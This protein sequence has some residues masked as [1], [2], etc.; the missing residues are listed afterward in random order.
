[1]SSGKT[2]LGRNGVPF[3][4]IFVV[5]SHAMMPANFDSYG[6]FRN[7]RGVAADSNGC[8]TVYMTV[9]CAR[10]CQ[11]MGSQSLYIRI[12]LRASLCI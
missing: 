7:R 1:V 4:D 11:G 12:S 10:R 8:T 9:A 2:D 5:A 3:A 6:G